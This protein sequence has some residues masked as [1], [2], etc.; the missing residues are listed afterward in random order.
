MFDAISYCKGAC[1][2]R[3]LFDV[4]GLEDFRKGLQVYMDRH[5]YGNTETTDLWRAWVESSG[6][7]VDEIMASWTEQMGFPVITVLDSQFTDTTATLKVK[8][9]W[10]LGD[11]SELSEEDAK[12]KWTIPVRAGS[13]KGAT[14]FKLCGE[15]EFTVEVPLSGPDDWV[16]LNFS[17]S[18]PV[19]VVYN[20][21]M[22]KRIAAGVR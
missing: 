12:K 6:K 14:E 9:S 11:G 13:S 3:M 21:D 5:K 15:P 17:Q 2:I 22:L 7:P 4:L 16:K 18:V 20:A 8:Q 10:F 1:V 19:R